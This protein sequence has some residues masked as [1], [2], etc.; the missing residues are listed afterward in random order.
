[1]KLD[2]LTKNYNASQRLIEV[3]TTKLDRLDKYFEEG[4]S[5]KVVLSDNGKACKMEIS[6]YGDNTTV[7]TEATGKTMYYN[8]DSC[9]PKLERQIVKAHS[10]HQT[11]RKI[12]TN[13]MYVSEVDTELVPITRVKQFDVARMTS[14]EAAQQLDMVDH[15]FY[16]FVNI[17]TDNVEVVYRRRDGDVG[18]LQPKL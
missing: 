12:D 4:A 11:K 6:I 3:L 10:R 9:L 8:I 18:H 17:D 16:I 13:Y 5:A 7:R 14:L 15:D 2:F 1:M